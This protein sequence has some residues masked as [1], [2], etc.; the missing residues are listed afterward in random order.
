LSRQADRL[1]GRHFAMKPELY[2]RE[3]D[4]LYARAVAVVE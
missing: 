2:R 4:A 3:Q 1:A